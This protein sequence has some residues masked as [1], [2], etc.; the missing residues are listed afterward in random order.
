MSADPSSMSAG[1]LSR[2]EA[3][4]DELVGLPPAERAPLLAAR[5][6][7]DRGLY[8]L[9]E[10]LLQND[11]SGMGEF[12]G[13]QV[14]TPDRFSPKIPARIG[15]YEILREIGRGGS[16]V[17]YEARQDHPARSVALKVL[18]G[19][20]VTPDMLR[21]F[22]HEAEI[23]GSL[24]HPSIAQVYEAG[25]VAVPIPLGIA[26]PVPYFAMELVRGEPVTRY[27]DREGLSITARLELFRD[28]CHAVQHAHQKGVIHRDLKPT[29]VLVGDADGTPAPKVIDFGIA[30]VT[31]A[32]P[33]ATP[34]LTERLQL[35]GTLEY[36]SPEQAE[37]SRD[38]DT[39]SDVYSLGVLL[40][41]LLTGTTPIEPHR[42]RSAT[43]SEIQRLIVFA[44]RSRPSA[45]AGQQTP[46]SLQRASQGAGPGMGAAADGLKASAASGAAV[47]AKVRPSDQIAALR[48]TD[49]P[50]LVRTLRGDLDW[51][52][53]KCLERDRRHRYATVS[54]LAEDIGCYLDQQPVSATPPSAGYKLRKF[55]RRNR[56]LVLAGAA[57][58]ASLTLGI[59]GTTLG[60]VWAI[61]ERG[62]AQQE[63][64]T[65]QAAAARATLEA[66]RADLEAGQARAINDFLREVLAS[67]DPD[68]RA[69]DVR[70]V[71]VLARA[72]DSVHERFGRYTVQEAE[73]RDLLGQ[74]Y[75]KLSLWSDARAQFAVSQ[76]LWA[77]HAGP[78]DPRTLA[79]EMAYVGECV[80][81]QWVSEVER[82]L[83]DLLPRIERVHGPDSEQVLNARRS[84]A[85]AL[86]FR[87]R[88]DEAEIILLDIR[89]HPAIADDDSMQIRVLH[90]LVSLARRRTTTAGREESIAILT[91][92]EPLAREKLERSVRWFG[93]DSGYTLEAEVNLAEILDGIGKREEAIESCRRV[94]SI[95]GLGECHGARL[96]A[97]DTLADA[98]TLMGEEQ[99]PAELLLRELDCLRRK[100]PGDN[101]AVISAM[102]EL[103][104]YLDR[105]GRAAEG[106]AMAQDLMASL[107]RF[108]DGHD[109]LGFRTD[110][111]I[112]HFTSVQGRLDEA[113]ALFQKLVDAEQQ[114][115]N[116]SLRAR[117]HLFYGG[118]L[119]RQGLFGQ[120]EA[121]L[122]T[123]VQWNGGIRMGTYSTHPDD[124][125]L[126]FIALYDAWGRTD[127]A[128]EYRHMREEVLSSSPP[129]VD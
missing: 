3:L 81:T 44:E 34:L 43:L 94:L 84:M 125:I 47:E 18:A 128:A 24:Q 68:E 55:A 56:G 112:A 5:C 27:C 86:M 98:L 79:A 82:L 106:E 9:V 25:T 61:R 41:E 73:V 38:I 122:E 113:D 97:L 42:L 32:G 99:E 40:Y 49:V 96:M 110:T 100:T 20:F 15:H 85:I 95:E 53:M 12:L 29:N 17:V 93:A 75:D 124:L 7:D 28:I 83:P 1:P 92:A 65:A 76:K 129:A 119:S 58:V 109:D 19:A 60:L 59:I 116:H 72:S 23:L 57:V 118:H 31:E 102:S 89:R 88:L 104:R 115:T 103:L 78:D 46:S 101:I 4:F 62:I 52:V 69:A 33:S 14:L 50:H 2:A 6:G 63:Q 67:P 26:A 39:R 13:R 120:A 77:A 48:G 123:A 80:N 111:Y 71:D 35:I 121:E 8:A 127:L 30:R 66:E 87:N 16:G 114:Q 108:G 21:R 105:A 22:T 74:V 11:D 45:R 54:A 37:L 117:L 36:M 91:E 70:L 64:H 10:Q 126:G 107:A 90:N 51:I